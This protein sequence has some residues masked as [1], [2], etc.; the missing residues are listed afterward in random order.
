MTTPTSHAWVAA[1]TV[2]IA[3]SLAATAH[4]TGNV[5]L[6]GP[7]HIDV[8]E[9]YCGTCRRPYDDVA[10]EPC[11]VVVEGNAHLRGGPIGTRR[12]RKCPVHRGLYTDC[13]DQHEEPIDY[14]RPPMPALSDI[15]G[16]TSGRR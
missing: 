4:R 14:G 10:D 1:T 8:L 11:I 12:N 5:L 15:M 3:E 13:A 7:T 9:V 6:V 2:T 16:V